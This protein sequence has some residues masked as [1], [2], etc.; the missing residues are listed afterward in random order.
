MVSDH[1]G[2]RLEQ[3]K[4]M[5]IRVIGTVFFLSVASLTTLFSVGPYQETTS[6]EDTPAVSWCWS[7]QT[8]IMLGANPSYC[9]GETYG[10]VIDSLEVSED[11]HIRENSRDRETGELYMT[12]YRWKDIDDSVVYGFIEGGRYRC[13][14]LIPEFALEDDWVAQDIDGSFEFPAWCG[15]SVENQDTRVYEEGAHPYDDV[16]M[17]WAS[18]VGGMSAFLYVHNIAEDRYIERQYVA[19]S[20]V[21]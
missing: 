7:H 21:E 1:R 3:S 20:H 5:V 8:E 13:E 18:D 19:K 2:T 11:Q 16:W 17:Y 6:V 14:R 15:G 10:E 12:E 4:S 9:L